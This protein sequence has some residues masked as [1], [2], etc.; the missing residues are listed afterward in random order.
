MDFFVFLSSHNL[1]TKHT[2]HISKTLTAEQI[3]TIADGHDGAA[4]DFY[5]ETR[6]GRRLKGSEKKYSDSCISVSQVKVPAICNWLDRSY[7]CRI[8]LVEPNP[9]PTRVDYQQLKGVRILHQNVASLPRRISDI[10]DLMRKFKCKAILSITESALTKDHP[11]AMIKLPGWKFVRHDNNNR[12]SLGIVTFYTNDIKLKSTQKFVNTDT[13]II[14]NEF[15]LGSEILH[16]G[17]VYRLPDA[18]HNFFDFFDAALQ[19]IVHSDRKILIMGD[20]NIDLF[21]NEAKQTQYLDILNFYQL[22]QHISTA[23]RC[24]A[25]SATLIDH[26]ISSE[27]VDADQIVNCNMMLSD[28]HIIGCRVKNF[29]MKV[30]QPIEYQKCKLHAIGNGFDY[31]KCDLTKLSNE[32]LDADWEPF[33]NALTVDDKWQQFYDLLIEKIEASTPKHVCKCGKRKQNRRRSEPWF[34]QMLKNLKDLADNAYRRYRILGRTAELWEVYRVLRNRFN[35]AKNEARNRYH[36]SLILNCETYKGKW[37]LLNKLRGKEAV[38]ETVIDR[39]IDGDTEHVNQSDIVQAMNNYLSS[40]GAKTLD[41]VSTK[42]AEMGV[43][44]HPFPRNSPQNSFQF[45]PPTPEIVERALFQL[46]PDKP[47]GPTG[48][49][50]KIIKS[51]AATLVIPITHLFETCIIHSTVPT[52]FKEAFVSPIYKK[53]DKTDPGNYR[54]ISVTG[55]FSK[56]FEQILMWQIKSH[57]HRYSVLSTTQYGF[58]DGHSTTHAMIDGMDHAFKQLNSKSDKLVSFLYLDLS[59]AFDVVPHDRLLKALNSVGFDVPSRNLM[60]SYLSDRVQATKLGTKLSDKKSVT[61]GVPQG[62]LLGPILFAI[63]VND[64]NRMLSNAFTKI[65]QYADDT[66]IITTADNK[67]DLVTRTEANLIAAKRF[68]TSLGL[69]LNISKTQFVPVT[70]SDALSDEIKQLVLFE[71]SST[72]PA[73]AAQSQATNLGLIV[74]DGLLFVPHKEKLIPKLRSVIFLIRSIRN[75]IPLSAAVN[76]YH[77]LFLSSTNYAVCVYGTSGYGTTA[78]NNQLEILHRK[79]LRTVH[80]NLPWDV[81]DDTLYSEACVPKLSEY[82]S[83]SVANMAHECIHGRAPINVSTTLMRSTNP[84]GR[85]QAEIRLSYALPIRTNIVKASFGYRAAHIWNSLSV[86]LKQEQQRDRFKR[87]LK[88]FVADHGIGNG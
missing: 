8:G 47:G 80:N 5:G 24:A 79:I 6:Q 76:L 40:I 42:A 60:F 39:I 31:G 65:V 50:P 72:E 34:T 49:P 51:V 59:K 20:L 45:I 62:S 87:R 66:C 14:F 54:P 75:L 81:S 19:H 46:K 52:H 84:R 3:S 48:I 78:V 68:F 35:T 38:G 88:K 64:C 22:N 53:G 77:T 58:R 74:D 36:K 13:S 7:L 16:L 4:A 55:T 67:A 70:N 9:G 21:R 11:N 27:S 86:E 25:Q 69:K 82:S 23:T 12:K 73:V 15:S 57:L 85:A 56:L 63:F 83:I 71:N 61:S 26:V 33:L 44:P 43:D 18:S 28:H 1:I 32:I 41:E 10:H 17:T 2:V 30:P 37:Q 29:G